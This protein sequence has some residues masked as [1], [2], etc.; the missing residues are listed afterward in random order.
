MS[1]QDLNAFCQSLAGSRLLS[2]ADVAALRS[3][4]RSETGTAALPQGFAD[5]L[6]KQGKLTRYQADVLLRGN[7]RFFFDDYKLLDRIGVG[8]MAG[9]FQAVDPRGVTVA[10]KVLPGSKAKE[11]DTLARF[12][13]EARLAM[14]LNHPNVVRTFKAGTSDGLH[15][16]AMEYLEG[17]TLEERL[18]KRGALPP[19]EAVRVVIEALRGLQHLHEKSM[20]HR[21]LKPANLMLVAPFGAVGVDTAKDTVKLLDIGLGRALFD[22]GGPRNADLTTDTDLLGTPDYMAPEQRDAHTVD[23][24][25]DIYSLGCVLYQALA[26]QVPFPDK[27]PVVKLSKHAK[28]M[29]PEP[30]LGT[31]PQA[32]QLKAVLWQM[33]AKDPAVRFATPDAAIAGLE[34]VL[35]APAPP[36]RP[37]APQSRRFRWPRPC[38]RSGT[39]MSSRWGCRRTARGCCSSCVRCYWRRWWFCWW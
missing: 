1:S 37:T 36:P 27:N 16:L 4:A 18:Q 13:R 3:R 32:V 21:D 25:A 5:W 12:Q 38:S 14:Q 30:K 6:V 24:R 34:R 19:A 11:P 22:E 10:I 31:F 33:L 28:T 35:M 17:E 20:I 23:I 39:P 8:R 26:G 15:Y 2:Q 7:T 9:V 29:P